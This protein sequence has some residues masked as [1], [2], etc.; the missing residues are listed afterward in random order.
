MSKFYFVALPVA[1]KFPKF[2]KPS[3][4]L[5]TH[6]STHILQS[7]HFNTYRILAKLMT[8]SIMNISVGKI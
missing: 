4:W 1:L 3:F 2:H 5:K 7:N 6:P 8:W